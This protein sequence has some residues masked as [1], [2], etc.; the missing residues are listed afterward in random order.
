MGCLRQL[1]N[2][3][4]CPFNSRLFDKIQMEKP[5]GKHKLKASRDVDLKVD[6]VRVGVIGW[7]EVTQEGLIK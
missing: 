3:H 7:D 2:P 1:S 6:G 5:I 4:E